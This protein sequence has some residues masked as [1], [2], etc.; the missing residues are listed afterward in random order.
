MTRLKHPNKEIEAALEHAEN[1]GWSIEKTKGHAHAWGK[2]KCPQN[3]PACWGG[4]N[5]TK[6]IWSTPKRPQDH[7]KDLK[8]IVDKCTFLGDDDD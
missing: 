8:R 2:M 3:D 4:K 7:A 1:R 6:S 5:C